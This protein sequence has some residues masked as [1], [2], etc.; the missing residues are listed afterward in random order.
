MFYPMSN[1]VPKSIMKQSKLV[2]VTLKVIEKEKKN[3]LGGSFIV[4]TKRFVFV[5]MS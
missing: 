1:K 2:T 5:K 4:F 3:S